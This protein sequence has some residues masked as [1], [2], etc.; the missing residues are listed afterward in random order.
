MGKAPESAFTSPYYEKR[1]VFTLYL[2]IKVKN[3]SDRILHSKII[4]PFHATVN[5]VD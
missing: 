5:T 4:Q 1:K 3:I 2:Y